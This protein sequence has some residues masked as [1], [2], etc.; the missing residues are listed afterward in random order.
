MKTEF[1]KKTVAALAASA[2]IFAGISPITAL[3]DYVE[4]ERE[5]WATF[6]DVYGELWDEE[7]AAS[8][9]RGT[10]S[11]EFKLEL[12]DIARE[13]A[14]SIFATTDEEPMDFSW[15]KSIGL[16]IAASQEESNIFETVIG[17]CV[18]DTVLATMDLPIDFGNDMVKFRMPEISENY[19]G[20]PFEFESEESRQQWQHLKEVL[21]PE[22]LAELTADGDEVAELLKRYG[23]ILF[24]RMTDISSE[25][26]TEKLANIEQE[27]TVEEGRIYADDLAPVVLEMAKQARDDEQLKEM[28]ENLGTFSQQ[29]NLYEEYQQA[30]DETISDM[31]ADMPEPGIY[32]EENYIS[33]RIWLDEEGKCAGREFSLVSGGERTAQ[34]AW[35]NIREDDQTALYMYYIVSDGQNDENGVLLGTGTITDDR[36]DG[37]YM[38]IQNGLPQF[39]IEVSDYDVKAELGDLDGTYKLTYVGE[40][41]D[42]QEQFSPEDFAVIFD[43]EQRAKEKIDNVSLTLTM[44]DEPVATLHLKEGESADL[45][46]ESDSDEGVVYEADNQED[47]Q[48]YADGVDPNPIIENC[49]KAGVPEDII[50]LVAEYIAKEM[51]PSQQKQK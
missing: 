9:E 8:Q 2:F 29:E 11:G 13:M 38:V 5:N 46:A 49:L 40:T 25:E 6:A 37:D 10:S 47:F 15:L 35:L 26:K 34:L 24:D 18:N 1:K 20:I 42:S 30:M 48:K 16:Q 12:G 33:A 44:E 7:M 43:I 14:G 23:D 22:F 31:E 51:Q 19:L 45:L 21:N 28:I 39:E 32:G 3:A 4:V 50:E 17:F 41:G 36:L 27:F